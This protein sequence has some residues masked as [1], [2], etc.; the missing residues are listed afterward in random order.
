MWKLVMTMALIS[1]CQDIAEPDGTATTVTSPAAASVEPSA[2]SLD[3]GSTTVLPPSS[4]QV[5]Q[6][7]PDVSEQGA[8]FQHEDEA[9]PGE[10]FLV[11][12]DDPRFLDTD[13]KAVVIKASKP[14]EPIQ[15]LPNVDQTQGGV[16]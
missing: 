6:I 10:A 16:Q 12:N 15:S 3:N 11:A 7:G 9:E 8:Y 5:E 2:A 14:M 1:G 4:I 13:S